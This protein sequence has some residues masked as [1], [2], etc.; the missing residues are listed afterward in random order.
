MM[1]DLG[2]PGIRP[3]APFF[4]T[5]TQDPPSTLS[6]AEENFLQ[7][8]CSFTLYLGSKHSGFC[9]IQNHDGQF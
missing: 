7:T 3:G 8:A 6:A 1:I 4:V 5:E 9:N 2:A